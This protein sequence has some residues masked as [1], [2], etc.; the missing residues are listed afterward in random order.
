MVNIFGEFED[1]EKQLEN[2]KEHLNNMVFKNLKFDYIGD[3]FVKESFTQNRIRAFHQ[4]GS[5]V[6][7]GQF[8]VD[9]LYPEF[10]FKVSAKSA[11]GDYNEESDSAPFVTNGCKGEAILCLSL[12]HI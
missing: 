2:V 6:I 7:A 11:N 1:I 5:A 10:K 4:G 12:I 9:L 3:V 8:D